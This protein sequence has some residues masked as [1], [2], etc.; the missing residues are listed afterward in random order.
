M[1]HIVLVEHQLTFLFLPGSCVLTI[2]NR[3]CLV[4]SCV[5]LNH[6]QALDFCEVLG[7]HVFVEDI[8]ISSH[9]ARL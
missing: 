5:E 2:F 3:Q 6:A 9:S 1:P 4:L 7:M 8:F